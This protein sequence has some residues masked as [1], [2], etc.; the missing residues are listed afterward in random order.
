MLPSATVA[1]GLAHDIRN[2][3]TT[4]RLHAD[5]LGLAA[6]QHTSCSR[7]VDYIRQAVAEL[8]EL[9]TRLGTL[10]RPHGRRAVRLRVDQE[11]AA[12][13]LLLKA[14][15]GCGIDLQLDLTP[16]PAVQVDRIELQQI[17]LNCVLNAKQAMRSGGRVVVRV[18]PVRLTAAVAGEFAPV[19]QP[20]RYVELSISDTGPGVPE[21][22]A[23]S[24]STAFHRTTKK[25]GWGLGLTVVHGCAVRAKGAVR[26]TN[27][28]AGGA[29]IAVALPPARV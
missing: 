25:S 15:V 3:L 28:K 14:A 27:G 29:C 17:V 11:V 22:V 12:M 8:N 21:S 5:L 24:A 4:V 16:S 7:H 9:I 19:L 23:R 6:P 20:G 18:R 26:I 1:A 13:S 10:A 2:I